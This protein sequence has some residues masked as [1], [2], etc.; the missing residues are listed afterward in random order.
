MPF[1]ENCKKR[2][3]AGRKNALAGS[4]TFALCKGKF[5]PVRAIH[6]VAFQ[7][8]EET[9]CGRLGRAHVKQCWSQVLALRETT[10]SR[11]TRF[12]RCASRVFNA[13]KGSWFV[14]RQIQGLEVFVFHHLSISKKL[15]DF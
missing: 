14:K 2:C 15:D 1:R 6:K 13:Q 10:K 11:S 8:N 4:P 12:R 5:P 9:S 7:E 3:V